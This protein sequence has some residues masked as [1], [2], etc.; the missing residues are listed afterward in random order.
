M[1]KLER[2]GSF[3]LVTVERWVDVDLPSTLASGCDTCSGQ[4]W[5]HCPGGVMACEECN[6]MSGLRGSPLVSDD[7]ARVLHDAQCGC[8][9]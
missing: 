4:R 7:Q 6:R 2:V 3:G 9:R 5:A 8:D 1:K